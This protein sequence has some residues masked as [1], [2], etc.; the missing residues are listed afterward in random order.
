MK[1]IVGSKSIHKTNAVL[2]AMRQCDLYGEHVF[3]RGI[4]AAS[5]IP[6]QPIGLEQTR[7][8]ASN[9]AS[10]AQKAEP[11]ADMWI[12]I[13]SGIVG[14]DGSFYDVSFVVL[15]LPNGLAYSALSGGH[16]VPKEYVKEA[17]DRG[18]DRCTAGA[19]MAERTGC[20]ATDNTIY[21]SNGFVSRSAALVQALMIAFGDWSRA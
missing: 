3:I 5:N 18:F 16:Q 20:D 2:E 13:E 9:R 1:I 19:V 14:A 8:G 4:P 10:N 7:M 11:A 12:G 17:S 6:E 15:L 21:V